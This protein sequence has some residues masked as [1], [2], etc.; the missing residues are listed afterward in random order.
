MCIGTTHIERGV[1]S[2]FFQSFPFWF[3]LLFFYPFLSP[4]LLTNQAPMISIK[5]GTGTVF[6]LSLI[7]EDIRC[8]SWTLSLISSYLWVIYYCGFISSIALTV[9]LHHSLLKGSKTHTWCYPSWVWSLQLTMGLN[10]RNLWNWKNSIYSE[11]CK[12]DS[13][14]GW[15][16]L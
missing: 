8:T 3:P 9:T 14:F 4:L 1:M 10:K 11:F 13:Y 12:Y 16:Q 5:G 7:S 6:I 15:I 2:G